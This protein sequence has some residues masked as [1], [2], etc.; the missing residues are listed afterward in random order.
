MLAE[1]EDLPIMISIVKA[2]HNMGLR[3]SLYSFQTEAG[4]RESDCRLVTNI[5]TV[6]LFFTIDLD[7]ISA[8]DN[9]SQNPGVTAS[10]TVLQ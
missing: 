10:V 7:D 9:L 8:F 2:L 6:R 5:R 4:H 3:I 1:L